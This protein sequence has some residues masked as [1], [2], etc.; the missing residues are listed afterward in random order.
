M[1]TEASTLE[2]GN[3]RAT[4]LES[5]HLW[6]KPPANNRA[7][8][9]AIAILALVIF[10]A[11]FG[12]LWDGRFF[13]DHW[14]HQTLQRADWTWNDLIESATFDLPGELATLW[15]QERPLQ[16]RYARPIA[17]AFMKL[18]HT[19]TGGDPFWIHAIAL[20]W[21]L[22]TASIVYFL[23]VWA[24][25][26]RG[27]AFFAALLF[28]LHPHAVF[29]LG[30][31][32]AR[33]ALV[34]GL[35]FV[36]AL[37]VYGLASFVG[38][39]LD[40]RYCRK[41][42]FFAWLLWLL[43]L[44]SR[45]T[46]VIFPLLLPVLDFLMGRWP[47][48]RQRLVVYGFF[49][50]TLAMYLYWRLAIFP[51][52]APPDIYFTAPTGP[53]YA[54]WAA[55]K[56][57]H[58]L[59]SQTVFT[60]MFLGL[61][62]YGQSGGAW[63]EYAVMAGVLLTLTIVYF[64]ATRNEPLRAFWSI[65]L[66][67]AFVP[68]IPVF[69]MPHFAYLA[70]PAFGLAVASMLRGLPKIPR[71][72][73]AAFVVAASLWTIAIYR[74][75]WRGIVRSE[76]LVAAQIQ[77]TTPIAELPPRGFARPRVYFL[78]LPVSAIYTAVALRDAWPSDEIEGYVLTFADHPLQMQSPSAIEVLNDH[79][80]EIEIK[81]GAY[82]AGMSGRMLIDG[83]RTSGPL[84][85]GQAID[86]GPFLARV[87]FADAT[88]IR[89]LRFTFHDPLNAPHTYFYLSTP[90]QPAARI[91]FQNGHHRVDMGDQ[92]PGKCI[93]WILERESHFSLL[94]FASRIVQSDLFLTG[95]RNGD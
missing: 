13:D 87:I 81:D 85:E 76:Q 58:M 17:M 65:W 69:V 19:L 11:Y 18:E 48:V 83:M 23:G 79:E 27:W 90:E 30:W 16:W 34:S 51:T 12:T 56:L 93:R 86:A 62:T 33:N 7:D 9:N 24:V 89:R 41:R 53:A 50:G 10:A 32:A 95:K 91:R 78:N 25:R 52:S 4:P 64:A 6:P 8:V 63:I 75:C 3:R 47:L 44:F 2:C 38:R 31:T 14:H 15:W 92:W 22:A 1:S 61:V 88:G 73:L 70:A 71:N 39:S 55:G 77:A 82:F 26:H 60:P 94:R 20:A 59:F 80:F 49:A 67:A 72:A 29:A 36:A 5:R 68:V 37:H 43:A 28:A 66:V 21:H 74:I 84:R 45:E 54:L 40:D 46:A 57:L 35:F 42:T